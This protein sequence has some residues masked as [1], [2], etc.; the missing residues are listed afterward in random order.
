L[1]RR[2]FPKEAAE[3]KRFPC[4]VWVKAFL[5]LAFGVAKKELLFPALQ[6]RT[7]FKKERCRGKILPPTKILQGTLINCNT[8]MQILSMFEKMCNFT[9]EKNWKWW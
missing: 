4:F 3:R 8:G 1:P 5:T 6:P 9:G 2:K 7:P